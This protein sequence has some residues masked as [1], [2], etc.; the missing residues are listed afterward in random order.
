MQSILNALASTAM[1]IISETGVVQRTTEE[2]D[3]EFQWHD[4][5]GKWVVITTVT[6]KTSKYLVEGQAD[7]L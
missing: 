1:S 4:K 6:I 2:V 5:Q 3:T 7:S